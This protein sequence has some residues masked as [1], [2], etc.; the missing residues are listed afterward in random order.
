MLNKLSTKVT[1]ERIVIFI[2]LLMV[3]WFFNKIIDFLWSITI[4]FGVYIQAEYVDNIFRRAALGIACPQDTATILI[5]FLLPLLLIK[6]FDNE[7][8]AIRLKR[9]SAKIILFV[10][11]LSLLFFIVGNILLFRYVV[12]TGSLQINISF[13]QRLAVMAPLIS[14]QEYKGFK[15]Q[16]AMMDGIKDYLTIVDS[17]EKRAEVLKIKLPKLLQ[18]AGK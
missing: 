1:K 15:A 2:L 11:T 3:T 17:M 16:W 18:R 7:I 6:F 12:S 4:S 13:N 5:V 14:E 10:I 9:V 8:Q